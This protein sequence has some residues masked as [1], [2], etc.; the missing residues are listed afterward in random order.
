MPKNNPTPTPAPG[1]EED[2]QLA[3]LTEASEADSFDDDE[4]L[5][6]EGSN[7]LSPASGSDV[8]PAQNAEASDDLIDSDALNASK[9]EQPEETSP[10]APAAEAPPAATAD[11][12]LPPNPQQQPESPPQSTAPPV[13]D[14]SAQPA[15]ATP[16]A[17]PTPDQMVGVYNEWRKES[18]SLLASH[19]YNLSQEDAEALELEP[20]KVIP[21]LMARVYLDAVSAAIG[22]ITTHLPRMVRLV[23]E[24]ETQNAK[25]EQTFYDAW[26]DLK[27]HEATVIQ[28]GQAYR[29]QNPQ[30]SAQ[31]FINNV[32]AMAMV[33]L[34]KPISGQPSAQP[35]PATQT[36][37]P[38]V[39]AAQTPMGGIPKQAQ[40][41]NIFTQLDADMFE[42]DLE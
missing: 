28:I 15:A 20:Q 29:A 22:Q 13:A 7:S 3:F 8:P 36:P 18:E 32:G 25:T 5:S 27:E 14:A 38:F 21:Q 42:E 16:S 34:K 33:A 6:D 26:P 19:H 35:T 30:A 23:T 31:D 10:A 24:Q 41:K 40:P 17:P 37:P 11:Q 12:A 39:P 4:F 9:P 2:E 1:E